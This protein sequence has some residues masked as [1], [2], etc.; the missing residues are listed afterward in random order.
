MVLT[1]IRERAI[2]MPILV[3]KYFGFVSFVLCCV[4]DNVI[5]DST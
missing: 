3:A 2:P 5:V 1:D 4:N